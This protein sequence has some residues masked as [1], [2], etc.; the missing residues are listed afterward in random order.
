MAIGSKTEMHNKSNYESDGLQEKSLSI[1]I[2]VFDEAD[3]IDPLVKRLVRVLADLDLPYEIILVDDGSRDGTWTRITALANDIDSVLGVK[4][5]RNF[6]HQYALWAGLKCAIGKAV[7]TMD[8]DLQH[9]PEVIPELIDNWQKGFDIVSTKRIDENTTGFF[10]RQT[11][12]QFYRVFS[13]LTGVNLGEGASDFRLLDR[14]PLN[15]LLGFRDTELFLRGAVQWLGFRNAIVSYNVGR[16]LAGESKYDMNRMLRFAI[17]AIVGF[18]TKPLRIGIWIGLATAS[19][20]FI[21]LIYIV[22]QYSL[23]KTVPGWASAVGVTSLLFGILFVLLGIIGIYL[24]HIHRA[25][26]GRP[27]FIV[28]ATVGQGMDVRKLDNELS[29]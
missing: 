23:G 21:E 11:S 16:R 27:H 25:L 20:A 13:Y 29:K 1:V 2:P 10:K 7:I 8:G 15:A 22:I 9:P 17:S 14:R 4:L 5:A 3:N 28:A 26:Q 12:K 18:S 24:A 6:G 19:L